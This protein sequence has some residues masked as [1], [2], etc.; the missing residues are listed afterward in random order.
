MN[1]FS[2]MVALFSMEWN[3]PNPVQ[4][5]DMGIIRNIQDMKLLLSHLKAIMRAYYDDHETA[6]IVEDDAVVTSEVLENFKLYARHA[7]LDWMI[8]QWTTNNP[9][10]NRKESHLLNDSWI[11]WSG[12][13]WSTIA[14]TIKSRRNETNPD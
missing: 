7:P 8:P 4:N 10:V 9:V 3:S 2:E 6:V 14:Y 12:H 11:S 5:T 13:H 1:P